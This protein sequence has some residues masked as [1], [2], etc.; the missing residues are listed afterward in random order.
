MEDET[1]QTSVKETTEG[2]NKAPAKLIPVLFLDE[3][4]KLPNLIQSEEA[5]KCTQN[6]SESFKILSYPT[7]ILDA[8]LV[9]TKQVGLKISIRH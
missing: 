6:L 2:E 3:A 1:G 8:I 7:G 4:H 9:L 5:M